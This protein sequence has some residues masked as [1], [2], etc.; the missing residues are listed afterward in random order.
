MIR[1]VCSGLLALV[2]TGCGGLRSREHVP[3]PAPSHAPSPVKPA[4]SPGATAAPALDIVRNDCFACHSED[5]LRQQRLTEA[6]WVKTIE[7]MHRWGAPTGSEDA[8]VLAA[9]L[10]SVYGPDAGPFAPAVLPAAEAAELFEPLDAGVLGNGDRE[11][12]LALY[13][14][15]CLACHEEG[16]RGGPGG[17]SLVG[18]RVLDR[19]ADFA[20]AIR[21][22]RGRMPEFPETT[23]AEAADLLS[24]LRSLP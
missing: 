17:V 4:G 6:Q 12:G 5:L 19:P 7:K 8:G 24:Y 11:R 1:L 16:G 21:R 14:E 10:A 2:A 3:S 13:G 22:G 20:S 15:R 18:R 9:Y 23:D